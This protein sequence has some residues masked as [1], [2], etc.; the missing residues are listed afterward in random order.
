MGIFLTD[1]SMAVQ[2]WWRVVLTACGLMPACSTPARLVRWARRPHLAEHQVQVALQCVAK[3]GRVVVAV[4]LEHVD[5]VDHHVG[6]LVDRARHVLDQHGRARLARGTH[7]GDQALQS[8][9]WARHARTVMCGKITL[10]AP[11][12]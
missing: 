8:K 1:A 7:N 6:Q 3:A 5:E 4:A 9:G 2:A 11:S 12:R 10:N